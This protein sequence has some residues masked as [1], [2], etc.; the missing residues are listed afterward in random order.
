MPRRYDYDADDIAAVEYGDKK[1]TDR[2][3]GRLEDRDA[4]FG[5]PKCMGWFYGQYQ[6]CIYDTRFMD[7]I[8]DWCDRNAT[9]PWYWFEHSINHGHSVE[10]HVWF[11][12]EADVS[13]FGERWAGKGSPQ[14]RTSGVFELSETAI[15][16]NAES[17]ETRKRHAAKLEGAAS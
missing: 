14:H 2:K 1:L 6:A 12:D 4:F 8:F 16:L 5:P 9:A 11:S 10:T 3:V 15:L 17:V 13:R 7:E